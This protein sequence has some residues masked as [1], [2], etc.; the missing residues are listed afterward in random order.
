MNLP[1]EQRTSSRLSRKEVNRAENT[2]MHAPPVHKVI[3]KKK[4]N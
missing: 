1:K 2:A 4:K 3:L